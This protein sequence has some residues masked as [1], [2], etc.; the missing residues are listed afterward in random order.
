MSS[1]RKLNN[2][3]LNAL[4]DGATG[5]AFFGKLRWF[6]AP[7]TLIDERSIEQYIAS[8]DYLADSSAARKKVAARVS[9]EGTFP[10]SPIEAPRKGPSVA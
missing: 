1:Q 7:K 2:I 8:P 9:S 6:G 3:F 4:V 5:A 10:A